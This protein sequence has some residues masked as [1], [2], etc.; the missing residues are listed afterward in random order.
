M[1]LSSQWIVLF[2]VHIYISSNAL[3]L[4]SV[5]S[6]HQSTKISILPDFT[7]C[8]VDGFRATPPPD[9]PSLY[10]FSF[11]VCLLGCLGHQETGHRIHSDLQ[12]A[13]IS[14]CNISKVNICNDKIIIFMLISIFPIWKYL[15]DYF[16]KVNICNN[17]VILS[18]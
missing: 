9:L 5:H 18:Y 11:F 1:S 10:K 15:F 7:A 14:L 2:S 3:W 4:N 8:S 13:Q 17:K 16:S 6:L 12:S